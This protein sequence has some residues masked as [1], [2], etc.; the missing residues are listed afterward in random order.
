MSPV[1]NISSA[2]LRPIVRATGTIGVEQNRPMF[3]PG[4]AKRASSLP[5]SRGRTRRRAGTRRRSRRREPSRSPAAGSSCSRVISSH[6]GR[7][8]LLVE[9][10]SRVASSRARSCPAEKAGP[11]P[12]ITSTGRRAGGD[13]VERL[14][15]LPHQRKRQRVAPV[16][17]IEGQPGDRGAGSS[18]CSPGTPARLTRKNSACMQ[19]VGGFERL[20]PRGE[21]GATQGTGADETGSGCGP[22]TRVGETSTDP[23]GG[24]VDESGDVFVDEFVV[25]YEESYADM[26]RLVF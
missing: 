21:S 14:E 19:G 15:H 18:S 25:L 13:R 6:A 22:D 26:A 24:A 11:R 23:Q 8:Q 7:E 20:G 2:R 1:N 4:V 12:S 16:G 17:P 5:R 3:T 10:A 9:P